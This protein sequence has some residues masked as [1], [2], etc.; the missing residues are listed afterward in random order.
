L[1]VTKKIMQELVANEAIRSTSREVAAELFHDPMLRQLISESLTETFADAE[2][3]RQAMR[4]R[5]ESE[6]GQR[7]LFNLQQMMEPWFRELGAELFGTPQDGLTKELVAVL[8]TQILAKDKQWL[9]VPSTMNAAFTS[10]VDSL[11]LT[12]GTQLP[13][14]PLSDYGSTK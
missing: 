5:W 8:R 1:A 9:V 3:M 7:F 11:R 10:P 14:Y 12:P 4:K 6:Q 13:A 2:P